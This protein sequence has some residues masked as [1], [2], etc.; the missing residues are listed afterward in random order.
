MA[1][2]GTYNFN[3]DLSDVV[4]EAFERA[5][6]EARTG[7]DYRTARRSLDLMF[8]EWQN[9]G[10][11]LW[12][13]QEGTQALTAGTSRYT[14]SADELDIVEAFVRINSGNVSSQAD[15]MLTRISISQYAH[16]TNKLETS[17]PLQYWIER[18]PNA[19]SVNLWPVPDDAETYSLIYYYMQRVED[20][21][22]VAS[23]NTDVPIRFLP[24]MIAGLAYYISIK[25]PEA[26]ERAPLL[27][28]MYE[29][30]WNL[31]A[32]ADREKASLYM[33]PGGYS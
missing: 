7:Y 33:I 4:E 9:R 22:S 20:S 29:E 26:T 11:N 2:S 5:G 10:L 15:Q 16:L 31:A 30:Q 8:L 24:C 12:T 19:I 27:K 25:R 17:K 1:T 21:G 3:L 23:N 28:Q 6:L 18:D 32:D 13:I 14:L